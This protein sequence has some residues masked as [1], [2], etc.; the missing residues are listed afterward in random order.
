MARPRSPLTDQVQSLLTDKPITC[1]EVA[2]NLS[3]SLGH[4]QAVLRSIAHRGDALETTAPGGHGKKVAAFTL[5]RPKAP[6]NR[7]RGE[8]T[9]E[10]RP[11]RYEPRSEPYISLGRIGD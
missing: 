9:G 11:L 3:I 2:Q 4:T 10:P 1:R 7:E 5:P 8:Y 6:R